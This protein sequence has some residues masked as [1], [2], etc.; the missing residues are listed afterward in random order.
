MLLFLTIDQRGI[1]LSSIQDKMTQIVTCH[2]FH[3]PSYYFDFDINNVFMFPYF[4]NLFD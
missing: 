2:F 1:F 4:Q 3:F